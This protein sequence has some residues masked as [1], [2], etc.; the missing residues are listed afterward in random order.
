MSSCKGGRYATVLGNPS[1]N[2]TIRWCHRPEPVKLTTDSLDGWWFSE[3]VFLLRF[4]DENIK[5]GVWLVED[6]MV[7]K[8]D[9]IV[10]YFTFLHNANGDGSTGRI[11]IG[12]VYVDVRCRVSIGQTAWLSAC[13]SG[14]EAGIQSNST[15]CQTVSIKRLLKHQGAFI[16]CAGF[17]PRGRF[18]V[19]YWSYSKVYRGRGPVSQSSLP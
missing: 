16:V 15:D 18:F 8:S 2:E 9:A 3:P 10:A 13:W 12:F 11:L 17:F 5:H 14:A 7:S 19:V 6:S 1:L 4:A